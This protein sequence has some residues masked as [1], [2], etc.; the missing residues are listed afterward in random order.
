MS[1]LV[2][3]WVITPLACIR[4]IYLFISDP[5][6]GITTLAWQFCAWGLGFWLFLKFLEM[7]EGFAGP[8]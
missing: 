1:L 3:G 4:L 7:F 2:V 6:F 5:S 8:R